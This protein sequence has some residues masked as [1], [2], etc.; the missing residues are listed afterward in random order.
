MILHGEVVGG[1]HLE[2]TPEDVT[3]C[4]GSKL[5][6]VSDNNLDKN[7]KT[8]CDPRLNGA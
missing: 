7:Y 2:S 3:E 1:I 4:V 5:D 6:N 8:A